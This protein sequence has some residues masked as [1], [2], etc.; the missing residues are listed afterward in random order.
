MASDPRTILTIDDDAITRQVLA[1]VLEEADWEVHAADSG[2]AALALLHA[3]QPQVVLSD[4]QMPGLSGEELVR[5]LRSM[6][7]STTRILAMSATQKASRALEAFDGFLLKPFTAEDLTATLNAAG[8]QQMEAPAND[9]N[10]AVWQKL[11]ASMPQP[12][13]FALYE[14]ALQDAASRVESMQ[15]ALTRQDY[16]TLHAQAH[17]LKGSAGMIGAGTLRALAAAI[18]DTPATA[19]I[20]TSVGEHLRNIVTGISRLRSILLERSI[21]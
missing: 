10:E 5:A 20:P 15:A 13:V 8:T 9:L 4:L 14:F 1:V 21:S 7:P 2:E 16:G 11:M 17:A 19:A 3:L 18:D 12:Q 6:V